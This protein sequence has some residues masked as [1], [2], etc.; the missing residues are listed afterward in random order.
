MT[1]ATTTHVVHL[2][3][4]IRASREEVFKAWTEPEQ[5][6]QWYAPV[7]RDITMVGVDLRVGGAYRRQMRSPEGS[8]HTAFGTYREIAPPD[9]LVFTWSWEE[10]PYNDIGETL[11]TI[12]LEELDGATAVTLRHEGLPTEERRKGHDEGW[13]SCLNRLEKRYA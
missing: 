12:S 7:G 13:T 4:T 5:M 10:E 9:R 6:K 8:V 2:T 3:R 11:M 1:P